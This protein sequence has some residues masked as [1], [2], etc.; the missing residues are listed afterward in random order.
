MDRIVSNLRE[1]LDHEPQAGYAE[2]TEWLDEVHERELLE[3]GNDVSQDGVPEVCK[4]LLLGPLP[5]VLIGRFRR[6]I[7]ASLPTI[8]FA[9]HVL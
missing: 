1:D 4:L 9:L 6:N 8:F 7:M 3:G 2:E 5:S